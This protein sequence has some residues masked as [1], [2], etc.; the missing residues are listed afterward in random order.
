MK[1][2]VQ[3][4]L[5]SSKHRIP[6]TTHMTPSVRSR[7]PL[8]LRLLIAAIVGCSAASASA[9]VRCDAPR[10]PIFGNYEK[11]DTTDGWFEVYKLPGNTFAL[12]EPRQAEHV[13][14]YLIVGQKR[15]LLFDS[16]FGI[17]RIDLV[18]KKLTSLPV[19]VLNSH[20]HYDHMGG[21]YAFTDVLAVDTDYTRK[22]A[23]GKP[24]S[25][26]AEMIGPR[27]ACPPLPE[28]VT[29]ESYAIRPFKIAAT[30]RDGQKMDLGGRE[31]EVL[32]TPGHTP[33][34][35]C[36]LDRAN[37]QMF[38]GD[39]LYPGNLWLF[40]PETD[41]NAYQRSIERLVKL[42][43]LVDVLRPAHNL[44][45]A[46]PGLF[47]K[48]AEALPQARSG[49]MPFTVQNDRRVYQFQG[50]SILLANRN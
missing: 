44:P 40:V 46:D 5:Q 41:L 21:N 35:L 10:N 7:R 49:K 6:P 34:A 36:V 50:F 16:G 39:T 9:Q 32:L 27:L 13:F 15:A 25:M 19:S 23:E 29:A 30:V 31:V 45:E 17:G 43:P 12:Y 18:V 48:V 14:S 24:N 26:M 37:R 20:T 11:L 33:D 1:D 22:S 42:A 2:D 8:L 38:T 47:A 3:P 28:G 4:E